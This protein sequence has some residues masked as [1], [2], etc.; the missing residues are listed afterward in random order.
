MSAKF[1]I[2]HIAA[3]A[4]LNLNESEREKF[5]RQLD[6]IVAYIDQLNELD[7]SGVEPMFHVLPLHNVFREDEERKVFPESDY[8]SGAPRRDKGHYEVPQILG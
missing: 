5:A 1:D 3:L 7:T 8:L 6:Q 4:R 2:Q